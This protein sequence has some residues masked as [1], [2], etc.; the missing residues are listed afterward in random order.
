MKRRNGGIIGPR[1]V[2]TPSSAKGR[3]ALGEAQELLGGGVFPVQAYAVEALIVAGGGGG[4][5]S[6][7]NYCGGGGAGGCLYYGSETSSNTAGT[8]KTPNGAAQTVIPGT[9]YSITVGAGGGAGSNGSDTTALGFTAIGGGFGRGNAYAASG[10][11]GGSGGGGTAASGAGGAGTSGQGYVGG[12][13][14]SA[15]QGGSDSGGGAGGGAQQPGNYIGGPQFSNSAT[16]GGQGAQYSIDGTSKYYAAGGTGSG[17]YAGDNTNGIGGSVYG[18]SLG[19][20]GMAN[21]GAGGGGGRSSGGGSGGSGVVV[22]RYL[23]A[24]KGTGGTIT[25]SGG[26]TIHTFTSSGTFTA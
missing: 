25:S 21:R 18:G 19:A 3:F 2:T 15:N 13:A 5:S 10:G 20:N 17:Y 6:G 1:N 7:A 9:A 22:I 4:G 8:Q 14:S 11:S 23:G 12:F 24:Q 26:Y 16:A